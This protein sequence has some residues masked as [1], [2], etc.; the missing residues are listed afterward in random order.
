MALLWLLGLGYGLT[1]TPGQGPVGQALLLRTD[2][3]SFSKAAGLSFEQFWQTQLK[4]SAQRRPGEVL[5]WSE[6]AVPDPAYLL[7]HCPT[8]LACPRPASTGCTS[9]PATPLSAGTVRPS[10]AA[11]TRRT[12]CRWASTFL[13]RVCCVHSTT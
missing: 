6:T 7:G 5:I 9:V 1:R 4:L 13:C 8:S 10:P 3:D 11:S 12:R 2:F